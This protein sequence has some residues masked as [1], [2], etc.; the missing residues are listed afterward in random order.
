M[1]R[2]YTRFGGGCRWTW[3][4]PTLVLEAGVVESP[5]S[6]LQL[7][8]RTFRHIV[9]LAGRTRVVV[10]VIAMMMLGAQVPP[11]RFPARF[12]THDLT[13]GE[14]GLRGPVEEVEERTIFPTFNTIS[15]YRFFSDGRLIAARKEVRFDDGNTIIENITC[16]Y[17]SARRI[18]ELRIV[19]DSSR[20]LEWH[21][22]S[23][24]KAGRLFS[25]RYLDGIDKRGKEKVAAAWTFV[26]DSL[27]RVVAS[28]MKYPGTRKRPWRTMT[29]YRLPSDSA[30]WSVVTEVPVIGNSLDTVEMIIDPRGIVRSIR[31]VVAPRGVAD[32]VTIHTFDSLGQKLTW[33][34]D[35][36]RGWFVLRRKTCDTAGIVLREDVT[37]Y[38]SLSG[39]KSGADT[40]TVV[41]HDDYINELDAHG[42]WTRQK[43]LSWGKNW[44]EMV[45]TSERRIVYYDNE[46]PPTDY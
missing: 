2:P 13:A 37:E 46:K 45:V 1:E 19:N 3:N 39:Y 26:H 40:G 22:W 34:F 42:N 23:Y 4:V 18:I 33:S 10:A 6:T 43:K 30:G 31:E 38:H 17:D 25:M 14:L 41:G 35:A 15:R 44:G 28:T 29:S 5:G 36:R 27:G 7:T 8:M 16:R 12:L 21:R 24:D 9:I 11:A 32:N 20:V